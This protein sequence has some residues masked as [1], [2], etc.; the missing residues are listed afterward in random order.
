MKAPMYNDGKEKQY[1]EVF[2]SPVALPTRE[3][4]KKVLEAIRKEHT[5]SKG[6]AELEAGIEETPKGFIA[7]RHHVKYK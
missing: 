6:W 4:A 7:I 5:E 3:A 2:R 1:E